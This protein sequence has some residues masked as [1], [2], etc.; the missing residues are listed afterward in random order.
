M[1]EWLYHRQ[2]FTD[3]VIY[4]IWYFDFYEFLNILK[5]CDN[6]LV[7]ITIDLLE[8]DTKMSS[9]CKYFTLK[10]I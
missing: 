9:F 5:L 1:S 2:T 3:C 6:T 7:Y 10:Y 4:T 8:L